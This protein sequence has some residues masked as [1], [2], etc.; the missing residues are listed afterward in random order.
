[1][2]DNLDTAPPAGMKGPIP[3]SEG[4]SLVFTVMSPNSPTLN[5]LFHLSLE[6]PFYSGR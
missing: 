4:Q 2:Q 6:P 1:M 5:L 3:V